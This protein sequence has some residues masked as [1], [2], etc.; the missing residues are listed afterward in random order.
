MWTLPGRY[1]YHKDLI[2]LQPVQVLSRPGLNPHPYCS[3][4]MTGSGKGILK[5]F[6]SYISFLLVR[7][8]G[9]ILI[10]FSTAPARFGSFILIVPTILWHW[11]TAWGSVG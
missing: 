11:S 2:P 3:Q 5:L 10:V 8:T 6:Y 9:T 7:K 4:Q 1:R